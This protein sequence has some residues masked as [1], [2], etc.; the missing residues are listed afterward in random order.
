VLC[1]Q[2]VRL[3]GTNADRDYPEMIRRV[4]YIDK[5]TGKRLVFLL[6]RRKNFSYKLTFRT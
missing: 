5:E 6:P 3:T 2:R 4:R 1:D